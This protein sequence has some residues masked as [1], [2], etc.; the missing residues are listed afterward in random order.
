MPG[1][2]RLPA[3]HRDDRDSG[4]GLRLAAPTSASA[5]HA[6][7][8]SSVVAAPYHPVTRASQENFLANS[9]PPLARRP[10]FCRLSLPLSPHAR[11]RR[12]G[13]DRRH[14]QPEP[15]P[16]PRR[17]A[18]PGTSRRLRRSQESA[19]IASGHSLRDI[20]GRARPERQV[21]GFRPDLATPAA[22]TPLCIV[23]LATLVRAADPD[24]AVR[25]WAA[26]SHPPQPA[27]RSSTPTR[28]ESACPSTR[29]ASA[30]PGL[31][32]PYAR[33]PPGHRRRDARVAA[34]TPASPP[35]ASP[36]TA[37]PHGSPG[38]AIR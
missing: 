24:R 3:K 9:L 27:R 38:A 32:A 23:A 10:L 17:N 2:G 20:G 16:S 28:P 22:W 35:P 14:A 7:G 21:Q 33:P 15:P 12:P 34:G 13:S 37:C 29:E 8:G 31:V 11:H 18:A 26:R 36:G 1:A 5:D 30:S 19:L 4:T 25:L 6:A